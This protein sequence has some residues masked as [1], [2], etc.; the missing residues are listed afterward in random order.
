MSKKQIEKQIA[1]VEYNIRYKFLNLPKKEA[2]DGRELMAIYKALPDFLDVQRTSLK[3]SLLSSILKMRESNTLM[4]INDVYLNQTGMYSNDDKYMD[5]ESYNAI[6]PVQHYEVN[7]YDAT[8]VLKKKGISPAKR[9]SPTKRTSPMKTNAKTVKNMPTVN[10]Q[11]MQ[12]Q[13]LAQGLNMRSLLP[14]DVKTNAL[15]K[16]VTPNKSPSPIKVKPKTPSPV[17]KKPMLAPFNMDVLKQ[18]LAG[19]KKTAKA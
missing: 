9:T 12:K 17:K 7:K 14:R 19:L 6:N 15:Q 4:K 1:A 11:T 5:D 18:G 10:M 13:L 2:L 3:E 16:L 8:Q